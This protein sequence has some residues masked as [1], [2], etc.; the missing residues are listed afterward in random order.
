MQQFCD[1][2]HVPTGPLGQAFTRELKQ[3]ADDGDQYKALLSHSAKKEWRDKRLQQ[4]L[5]KATKKYVKTTRESASSALVGTY[6]SFRKLWEAEGLDKEGYKALWGNANQT[7]CSCLKPPIA[8]AR[9]KGRPRKGSPR[10]PQDCMLHEAT[11]CH[12]CM[13]DGI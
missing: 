10:E 8:L 13:Y 1:F 2:L 3:N 11:F 12:A 4:K 6:V 5:E 7:P 9:P